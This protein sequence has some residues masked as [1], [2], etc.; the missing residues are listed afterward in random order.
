LVSSGTTLTDKIILLS[1]ILKHKLQKE[2]ELEFYQQELEKLQQKMFFLN[3]DIEIT[4]MCI[5][6]IEQEK[7][8]S[9][10]NLI[11]GA[12]IDD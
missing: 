1:D 12:K 6:I 10:T 7:V 3:K 5:D 8:S 11:T 4:N 2:R 9:V